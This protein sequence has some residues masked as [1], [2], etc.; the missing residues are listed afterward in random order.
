MLEID[1]DL[2]PQTCSNFLGLV[3]EGKYDGVK[4]HRCIKKFMIQCGSKKKDSYFGGSFKDEFDDR[5]T[6]NGRGIVAMANAGAHTNKDQFYITFGGASHLDRK[7]S[8]FGRVIDGFDVIDTMESIPTDKSDHPIHDIKI[9]N[10]EIAID[11]SEEAVD[12][13]IRRE[14]A[15]EE[16]QTSA[17]N[18][19]VA[20]A[21]GTNRSEAHAVKNIDTDES[22][23]MTP[24]DDACRIKQ[25][26]IGRYLPNATFGTLHDDSTIKKK[27]SFH[28]TV[29]SVSNQK[30]KAKSSFG[31]FSSW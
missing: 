30:K 16:A 10:A 13:E 15:K 27:D 24:S 18:A 5:L 20:S 6:H 7:H 8:V 21:L 22:K 1:C 3:S 25:S 28:S 14:R 4:F 23:P 9:M 11:P 26:V 19:R 17:K 29:I 12:D 31:D 2:V